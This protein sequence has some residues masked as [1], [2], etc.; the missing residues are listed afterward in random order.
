MTRTDVVPYAILYVDDEEQSLKYFPILFKQFRCLTAKSAQEARQI[1]AQHGASIGVLITDQRMPGESGVDLLTW[2]RSAHPRV[3]RILTTAFTDLDSAIASVNAGEIYRYVVKPWNAR[4]LLGVLT[5]ALDYH[6]LAR[7]RDHLL[8]EKL[9]TLQN[10]VLMDRTRGFAILAA[11]LSGHLQNTF[12]ALKS[13]LDQ[14]P[15]E[16]L[17]GA[18]PAMTPSTDP[19]VQIQAESRQVVALTQTI[20]K[21]VLGGEIGFSPRPLATLLAAAVVA[22]TARGAPTPTVRTESAVTTLVS[23]GDL[24]D[25]LVADLVELV[26]SVSATPARLSIHVTDAP[27]IGSAPAIRLSVRT[28]AASWTPAQHAALYSAVSYQQ[29]PS[30]P[31]GRLLSAHFLTSHHAGQLTVHPQPP[32][33][34]GIA[35]VVPLDPRSVTVAA[36]P[37]TWV[38][39]ILTFQRDW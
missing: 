39:D 34:P 13:Y 27:P 38:D 8:R 15:Q 35:V 33:G 29:S 25:R 30:G 23:D 2:V 14:A 21:Q 11:G 5:H 18:A 10:L 20:S 16:A 17:T 37:G 3:V 32:I 12:V 4:E 24:L 9:S 31:D 1:F 26:L 7:E 36:V 22:A 19:S 6:L 28:D